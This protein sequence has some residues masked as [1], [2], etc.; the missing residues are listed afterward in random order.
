MVPSANE[1]NYWKSDQVVIL[2]SDM[3]PISLSFAL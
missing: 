3:T 1:F 2:T